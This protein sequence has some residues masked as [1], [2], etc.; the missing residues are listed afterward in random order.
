MEDNNA[1]LGTTSSDL[2]LGF[3]PTDPK[4]QSWQQKCENRFRLLQK[5]ENRYDNLNSNI[6]MNE[7]K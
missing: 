5:C 4:Q 2:W 3:S 7:R 1:D 6:Q